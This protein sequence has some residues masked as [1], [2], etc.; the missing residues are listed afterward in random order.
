M[1]P[2]PVAAGKN[3]K[4]ATDNNMRSSCPSCLSQIEHS[5]SENQIVCTSCGEIY[6]PFVAA[7][8]SSNLETAPSDFSE[9]VLAFKEI[10]DFG[11]SMNQGVAAEVKAVGKPTLNPS[12]ASISKS[13]APTD[14]ILSTSQLGESY[15]VIQWHSPL[16]RMVLLGDDQHPLEKAFQ[17]LKEGALSLGAN[18]VIGLQCS[19]SPD[20]KRALIIG[21]PVRCE[22]NQ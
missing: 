9:S 20:N 17:E 18:A 15:R 22:K 8:D 19:L 21:T 4:N 3:I 5:H 2:A 10:V 1:T 6:S 16:S 14:F 11:Q 13:E 7:Q 12:M